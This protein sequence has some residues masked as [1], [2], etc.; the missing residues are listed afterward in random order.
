MVVPLLRVLDAEQVD[1]LALLQLVAIGRCFPS[2][3]SQTFDSCVAVHPWGLQDSADGR[4]AA[5]LSFFLI[6][7]LG[8]DN[9]ATLLNDL[10]AAILPAD[11]VLS[12]KALVGHAAAT[13]SKELGAKFKKLWESHVDDITTTLCSFLHD[14]PTLFNS[15]AMQTTSR[16]FIQLSNVLSNKRSALRIDGCEGVGRLVTFAMV[17]CPDDVCTCRPKSCVSRQARFGEYLSK[18][19]GG[20]GNSVTTFSLYR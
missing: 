7:N 4:A 3:L 17:F 5:L 8:E 13:L 2:K 1:P 16:F 14:A 15:V 9:S 19:R 6:D 18:V 11:S 20:S 10:S 12:N